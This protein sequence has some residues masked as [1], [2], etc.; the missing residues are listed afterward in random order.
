MNILP[1]R[2]KK[3]VYNLSTVHPLFKDF[4]VNAIL[5]YWALKKETGWRGFQIKWKLEGACLS[6]YSKV[7]TRIEQEQYSQRAVDCSKVAQLL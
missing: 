6:V 3:L 1:I 7:F 5:E 2:I 4:S